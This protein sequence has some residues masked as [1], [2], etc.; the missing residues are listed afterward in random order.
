MINILLIEDDEDYAKT[1]T[2]YMKK[3]NIIVTHVASLE[4]NLIM[5]EIEKNPKVIILDFF[6]NG[7]N[8]INIYSYLKKYNIPI[9]YLTSNTKSEDEISLLKQGVSDYID[10]LKPLAVIYEKIK[11]YINAGNQLEYDFFN[12]T[13]NIETKLINNKY[14]LTENEYKILLILIKN[15]G[16]NVSTES[17]MIELWNDNTFIEKNTVFVAMKRLREKLRKF[18]LNVVI[19]SEKAKGYKLDELS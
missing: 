5:R 11:K 18:N 10:K 15:I 14:K 6:F 4:Q 8:S 13:L 17:I 1:F 19:I 9:V 12:N 2:E 16:K 3:N 7:D